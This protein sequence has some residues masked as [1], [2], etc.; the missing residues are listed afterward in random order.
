[1]ANLTDASFSRSLQIVLYVFSR[2]VTALLP[3]EAPRPGEHTPG[4]HLPIERNTFTVLAALVWGSVMYMFKHHR[5][6]LAGG[7]VSSMQY[8]CSFTH[9][10]QWP[11]AS[12][13]ARRWLMPGFGT[14]NRSRQ[15]CLDKLADVAVA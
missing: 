2:V 1:M 13:A 5:E 14:M 8:L 6:R 4:R 3:R 10:H 9:R 7:M 11:Q 12:S 15:R